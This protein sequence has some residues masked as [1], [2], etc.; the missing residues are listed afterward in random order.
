MRKISAANVEHCPQCGTETFTKQVSAPSFQLNGNGWYVTDFKND[1][2]APA[3]KPNTKPET[4]SAAK[5]PIAA[6]K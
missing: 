2:P 3:I 4:K 5:S 6:S 1:K